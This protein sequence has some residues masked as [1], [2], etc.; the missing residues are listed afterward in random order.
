MGENKAQNLYNYNRKPVLG[1]K[2]LG[3]GVG[4]GPGA[5]KVSSAIKATVGGDVVKYPRSPLLGLTQ[6]HE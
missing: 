1:D 6:S 4:R 5:L 2:F 3:I